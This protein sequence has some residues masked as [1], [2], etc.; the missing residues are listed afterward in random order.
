MYY[1]GSRYYDPQVKR[2]VNAD[3]AAFATIN[4]YSDGLTDKNYFAYCDNDPVSRS[5]DGGTFFNTIIGAVVGGLTGAVSA[6]LSGGSKRE[7]LA[8]ATSGAVSGAIA[9]AGVD[10]AVATVATGGVGAVVGAT[11]F[12]A[13]TGSAA[14]DVTAA[15]IQRKPINRTTVNLKTAAVSAVANVASFGISGFTG[16]VL[17]DTFNKTKGVKAIW[18]TVVRSTKGLRNGVSTTISTYQTTMWTT[19]QR[20]TCRLVTSSRNK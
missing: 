14:G 1:L 10:F 11:A 17:G 4:P 5:D 20:L 15:V 19:I 9:G 12:A 8:S 2:F 16:K 13:I 7:V 6:A 18:K 3:G